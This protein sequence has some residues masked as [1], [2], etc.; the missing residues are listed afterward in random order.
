MA[1]REFTGSWLIVIILLLICW[2]VAIIYLLIH[3]EERPSKYCFKCGANIPAQYN[4]CP[5]CG[6]PQ[7]SSPPQRGY[8][9]A[10]TTQDVRDHTTTSTTG[11]HV[12]S[13][14]PKYCGRCGSPTDGYV[15]PECGAKYEQ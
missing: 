9:Y 13:K 12:R 1:Q 14:A 4:I 5:Y 7:Y 3:Y 11:T 15:C 2:P 10:N 6:S 8:N